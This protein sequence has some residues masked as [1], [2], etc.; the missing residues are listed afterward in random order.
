MSSVT[1]TK[2][3]IFQLPRCNITSPY[4]RTGKC[5]MTESIG[6]TWGGGT[7]AP[8]IFFNLRIF[9]WLPTYRQ[10]NKKLG[11]EWWKLIFPVSLNRLLHK[12][13][14]LIPKVN[15]AYILQ[16]VLLAKLHRTQNLQL[17]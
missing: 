13:K 4:K 7:N 12:L 16:P 11:L 10:V 6:I 15:F 14:F 2:L 1:N 5:S 9:F 8:S 3:G 17:R